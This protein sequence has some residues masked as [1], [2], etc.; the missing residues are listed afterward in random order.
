MNLQGYNIKALKAGV[1]LK[2]VE[3]EHVI[4][5]PT[6]NELDSKKEL[7]IGEVISVGEGV[8]A[9]LEVGDLIIGENWGIYPLGEYYI[10]NEINI[11]CKAQKID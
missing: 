2:L 4:K 5:D 7:Y 3:Q 9:E 6:K 10:T 11:L 8:E 1:L